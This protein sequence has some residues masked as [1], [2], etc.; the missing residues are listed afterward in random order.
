MTWTKSAVCWQL[1]SAL[2]RGNAPCPLSPVSCL[3]SSVS[4]DR[5][6]TEDRRQETGDRGH[7]ALP[8]QSADVSCQH[9]A[10]FVHVIRSLRSFY[11]FEVSAQN[12]VITQLFQ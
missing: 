11:V 9:T 6:E 3:L 10:D 12:E 5:Q 7:G 1:T 4:G 2:C 8:L